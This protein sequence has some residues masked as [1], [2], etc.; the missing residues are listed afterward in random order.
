MENL[1]NLHYLDIRGA[2]SI[3]R[4]PFGIGKLTNLQRLSAF[5]IG[6][7]DGCHIRDLKYLT[8]LK[9]DFRLSGLDNVNGK[10]AGEAK[11]NEKQGIDRLVLE[12]SRDFKN[13][14]RKKKLKN[15][16]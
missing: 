1:V 5:I 15:G 8:N 12:W 3:G 4:M 10:D 9:G 13:D 6:E 11:L 14:I 7:G 2:N 16:C